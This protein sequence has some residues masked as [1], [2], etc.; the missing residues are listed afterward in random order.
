MQKNMERKRAD[1][2]SGKTGHMWS[3]IVL[4]AVIS[5]TGI[6]V[7]G[8]PGETLAPWR[9]ERD[10]R[11]FRTVATDNVMELLAIRSGMTILDIGAGTGQFAF[12]F[13]RRL[14]GTGKVY[15]TDANRRCVEYMKQEA[16]I[17][18]LGNLHPV[19]VKRDGVDEFYGRQK[20]DLIA[21]FHV[22]MKYED[23]AD[24]F[25]ELRGFLTEG[26]RLVL[27]LYKVAT[28]FSPG[29][30]TGDLRGLIE[31]LSREPAGSPFSRI[32][33]DSTR[34]LI[35]D[36]RETELAAKLAGALADDFNAMLPDTRFAA[37]FHK[38]SV[39]GEELKL[40]PEEQGY[41]DWMLLPYHA[42]SARIRDTGISRAADN[43][44]M[45]T[46]NKLLILQRYRRFIKRD[47]LFASGF[48]LP[49][50]TAFE[51]AGYRA[52]AYT[53][54]IPYEDLVVLS[55]R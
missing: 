24:Y 20:Y 47:G 18:G 23:Q 45:A 35:R 32:L 49:I 6:A 3:S 25:R 51:K 29:D 22:A 19:H 2:I 10:I 21:V 37:Q 55:P 8:P 7:A 50:R 11:R 5:I 13:A 16:D 14:S 41:A 53:D 1:R 15:A 33:S 46:L 26:G 31:E 17:K 28:P 44:M 54:L 38:G 48:T 27:I 4:L 30:F 42:G 12:E 39:H 40:S 43:R 9:I 52:Q 34:K 36:H